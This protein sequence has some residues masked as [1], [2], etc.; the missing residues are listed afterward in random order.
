M[1]VGLDAREAFRQQPRGIG[2]YVRH[3]LREFA[4]AAPQHEYLLYHQLAQGE[5]FEQ[6][7]RTRSV[8]IDPPGDRFHSWER[9]GVPL[10]SARD[11]L[12]VYHG[13]YNTLPPRWPLLRRT[14]MVV[15]VHD[16]I[17]TWHEDDLQDSY[18]RYCRA[19]TPRVLRDADI[20]LTVSEWSRKDILERHHVDPARVRIS[21]NGI[22]PDFLVDPPAGS[23][24]A[25]R[26]RWSDGRPYVF[27]VGAPLRR[28]NTARLIEAWGRAV[29]RQRELPHLLLVSGLGAAAAQFAEVAAR[30]GAADRVRLLPYVPREELRSLY[31]GADLTVYPSLVEGWG[32]PVVE[33]LAMG[34][35][36]LTS[37][38]SAMPEAGGRF[39]RYF[40]P[41]DL[42]SMANG[43]E[44][45]LATL[46]EFAP[47]RAEAVAHARSFTWARTAQSVLAAYEDAAR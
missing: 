13:T 46:G 26:T 25:M 17:V 42:D 29:A 27:S 14:P 10:R 9:V 3:L 40:D 34:T 7:P 38:T 2:L 5:T 32:I 12:S 41:A 8:R 21:L 28:K 35:P 31:A 19:V 44:H 45:A 6:P 36:V 18:V 11:A 30:C 23:G 37:N 33:S 20:V 39:A 4:Q 43:L 22:H 1:R 24:A 47:L 16:L 15:T